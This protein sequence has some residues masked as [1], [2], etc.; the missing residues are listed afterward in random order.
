MRRSRSEVPSEESVGHACGLRETVLIRFAECIRET[1]VTSEHLV[2][3][4]VA[5]QS[6]VIG[7]S[8]GHSA[9]ISI[10][11]SSGMM[12]LQSL[13]S[14]FSTEWILIGTL[15]VAIQTSGA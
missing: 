8:P 1:S 10:G 9:S 4:S 3:P 11:S 2:V 14:E 5:H 12:F 15:A 7:A 6:G 13:R